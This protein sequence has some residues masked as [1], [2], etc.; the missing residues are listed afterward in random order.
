MDFFKG[1]DKQVEET[2][3][4]LSDKYDG[5]K[6]VY[7]SSEYLHGK[8]LV[9]CYPDGGKYKTDRVRVRRETVDGKVE[10]LDTYFNIVIREDVEAEAEAICADLGLKVKAFFSAD[11]SYI[12]NQFDSSKTYA[13]YMKWDLE[14]GDIDCTRLYNLVIATDDFADRELKADEIIKGIE[15]K[16]IRCE[17]YVNFC[18]NEQFE[19]YHRENLE[20]LKDIEPENRLF[21]VTGQE[22]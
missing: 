8:L 6:F 13:D 5:Q 21:R 20:E 10:Y 22:E 11:D 15:A 4:Y 3:E 9:Y 19:N 1:Q 17:A 2:L 14:D 16:N 7:E 18:T 12:D